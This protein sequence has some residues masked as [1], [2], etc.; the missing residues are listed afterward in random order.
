MS[1]T[2]PTIIERYLE[3][4]ICYHLTQ[5]RYKT[6]VK[7]MDI[8]GDETIMDFGCG[9]GA[10]SK[11]IHNKLTSK[12]TLILLDTSKRWITK[13]QQRFKH[14]TNIIF[15][16]KDITQAP[17][18]NETIDIITMTYVIHDIPEQRHKDLIQN[19]TE[20]LKPKGRFII[21][22]PTKPTHGIQITK[23]KDLMRKNNLNLIKE[24]QKKYMYFAIYEK[25]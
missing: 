5:P 1:F 9:G 25:K 17:I 16:N 15:I 2:Q 14:K 13:A 6:Y 19:L 12:G 20:K 11:P 21:R 24:I 23:I 10:S 3:H 22:E 8:Q 7:Y 18:N 4:I